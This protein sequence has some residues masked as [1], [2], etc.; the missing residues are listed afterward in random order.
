LGSQ[1]T[2]FIFSPRRRQAYWTKEI[3]NG[4]GEDRCPRKGREKE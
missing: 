3:Q 2:A 4:K 1:F